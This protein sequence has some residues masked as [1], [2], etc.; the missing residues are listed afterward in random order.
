VNTP[1]PKDQL[2]N[3]IDFCNKEYKNPKNNIKIDFI[4]K[5]DKCNNNVLDT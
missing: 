4:T 1:S 3:F 2:Q 5:I